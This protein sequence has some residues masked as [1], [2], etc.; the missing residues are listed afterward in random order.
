[1]NELK[2]ITGNTVN[3]SWRHMFVIA[4][5]FVVLLTSCAIKNGL[6][7]LLGFP[8]NTEQ[9]LANGKHNFIVNGLQNC[10]KITIND[11]QLTNPI[12]TRTNDFFPVVILAAAFLFLFSFR[13]VSNESKH[14][15]YSSSG[16]I[17][18]SIPIFLEYRKLIIHYAH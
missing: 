13:P 16:K 10:G 4:A 14:P 18:S 11:T 3:F 15:L 2:T 9:R 12:V 8:A 7:T 6:K 1:M 5:T 17:R